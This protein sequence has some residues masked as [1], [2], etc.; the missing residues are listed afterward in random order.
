MSIES[1]LND[2]DRRLFEVDDSFYVKRVY[3]DKG[4]IFECVKEPA[5]FTTNNKEEVYK[6]FDEQ[7]ADRLGI[8]MD[9]INYCNEQAMQKVE[10]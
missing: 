9:I 6:W 2:N 3:S 1:F 4:I 5:I 8:S 7:M 10:K